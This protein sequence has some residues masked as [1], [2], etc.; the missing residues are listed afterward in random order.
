MC[1]DPHR[2]THQVQRVE[3]VGRTTQLTDVDRLLAAAQSGSGS[4]LLVAGDA[5]IGKTTYAQALIERA[6]AAGARTAWGACLEGPGA[7]P[8]RPWLQVLRELGDLSPALAQAD[9]GGDTRYQL[10][11]QVVD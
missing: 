1:A 4:V 10:F 8:Y 11:D 2:H 6:R 3:L 7:A 9:P 5:G